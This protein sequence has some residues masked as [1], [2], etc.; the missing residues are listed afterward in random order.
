MRLNKS[1]YRKKNKY[2]AWDR[3]VLQKMSTEILE[4]LRIVGAPGGKLI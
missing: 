2:T 1:T 4:G 3:G